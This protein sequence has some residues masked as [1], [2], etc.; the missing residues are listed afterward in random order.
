MFQYY[1][2]ACSSKFTLCIS[3]FNIC[4]SWLV[5]SIKLIILLGGK[6]TIVSTCGNI[7]PSASLCPWLCFQTSASANVTA[8][9]QSPFN[10]QK[11]ITE[12]GRNFCLIARMFA[13]IL[14]QM[15]ALTPT[16]ISSSYAVLAKQDI[17]KF[18]LMF[19]SDHIFTVEGKSSS[20]HK[21]LQIHPCR[22]VL[23]LASKLTFS[24][25]VFV[26]HLIIGLY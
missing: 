24:Y 26:D 22:T 12:G 14:M 7:R 4:I 20:F 25:C 11:L 5:F 1:H 21:L 3:Q 17:Q 13:M 23:A 8:S 6:L 2:K 15:S 10:L 16:V 18:V 9:S 19:L